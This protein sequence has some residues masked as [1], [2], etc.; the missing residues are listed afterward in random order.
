MNN[1]VTKI[2]NSLEGID[3]RLEEGEEPISDLDNRV[4]ESNQAIKR[5]KKKE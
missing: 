3:S 5:I 2:K 1:S 4:M